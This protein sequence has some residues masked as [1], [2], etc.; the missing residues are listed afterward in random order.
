M[1]SKTGGEDS[2]PKNTTHEVKERHIKT[3]KVP[4]EFLHDL[5][6]QNLKVPFN[7]EALRQSIIN[8]GLSR[9]VA[10]WEDPEGKIWI[11][12]GHTRKD[13]ILELK[14]DESLSIPDELTCEFYECADRK[15]AIRRLV[16]VF[17]QKGDPIASEVF[18]EM[19][20]T[21]EIDPE[22][23]NTQAINLIDPEQVIDSDDFGEGFELPSGEKS[24]FQQMTFTLAD[25][26]AEQIKE[27]LAKVKAD[28]TFD[29]VET[30]GNE[31]G[32][33]NALFK[34]IQEW[35]ELKR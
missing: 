5:Q 2:A 29:L 14:A 31:N 18:V 30:F 35:E 25:Q 7:Q 32:N 9:N 33:G 34:I 27:A 13:M 12:D 11:L 19:L 6:P 23:I 1:G 3:K 16:N 20:E 4:L 21:E 10:V 8:D 15:D 24:P 22:D 17:N 26:Q 28:D